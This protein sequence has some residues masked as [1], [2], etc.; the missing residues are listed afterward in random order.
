MKLLSTLVVLLYLSATYC[1]GQ[2]LLSVELAGE[3]SPTGSQNTL[4]KYEN[5]VGSFISFQKKLNEKNMFVGGKVGYLSTPLRHLT[6]IS[7][8]MDAGISDKSFLS[9]GIGVP[10]HFNKAG[11]VPGELARRGYFINGGLKYIIAGDEGMG[12]YIHPSVQYYNLVTVY[13]N[14]GGTRTD[15]NH[16]FGFQ[17]GAGIYFGS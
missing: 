9:L 7:L 4:N 11:S 2:K 14:A 1:S 10:F 13:N 15:E 6:P 3:I 16:R 8:I 12:F 17:L 5:A